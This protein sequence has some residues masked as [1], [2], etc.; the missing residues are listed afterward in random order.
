MAKKDAQQ[1]WLWF[2]GQSEKLFLLAVGSQLKKYAHRFSHL[3]VRSYTSSDNYWMLEFKGTDRNDMGFDASVTLHVVDTPKQ[4]ALVVSSYNG[5]T[6]A[7]GE[8]KRII[9][10]WEATPELVARI[11]V[12]NYNL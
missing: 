12:Q 9:A 6:D 3:S 2:N 7:H 1:S 8:I 11:I 10:A 5:R 4:R